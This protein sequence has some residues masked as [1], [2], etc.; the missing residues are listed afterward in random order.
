MRAPRS[1]EQKH[2]ALRPACARA[3]DMRGSA[4]PATAVLP[5]SAAPLRRSSESRHSCEVLLG[6]IVDMRRLGHPPAWLA[7][8]RGHL[9]NAGTNRLEFRLLLR[10][11]VEPGA[12]EQKFEGLV[13]DFR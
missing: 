4:R 5:R 13:C 9:G 8:P 1:N 6:E 2:A 10:R 7:H 12:A 11:Q 3:R